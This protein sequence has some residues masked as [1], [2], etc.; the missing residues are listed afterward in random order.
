MVTIKQYKGDKYQVSSHSKKAGESGKRHTHPSW[1]EKVILN[2]KAELIIGHFLHLKE[3]DELSIYNVPAGK[4][5]SMKALEDVNYLVVM[6]PPTGNKDDIIDISDKKPFEDTCGMITDLY[7]SDNISIAYVDVIA[8]VTKA[9]K[10]EKMEEFYYFIKGQGYMSVG[11]ERLEVRK[12]DLYRIPIGEPHYLE[13]RGLGLI[14][15]N[16]PPF[17]IKDVIAIE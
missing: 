15:V 3:D 14:V 9:H 1:E 10:H 17:D 4:Y 2:K 11:D 5:H 13:G 16:S 8:D 6:E 7:R 12:G